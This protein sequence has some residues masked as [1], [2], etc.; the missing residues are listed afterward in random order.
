[1]GAI[2]VFDDRFRYLAERYSGNGQRLFSAEC[3]RH[4]DPPR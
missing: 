4:G 2:Y 3:R 1:M